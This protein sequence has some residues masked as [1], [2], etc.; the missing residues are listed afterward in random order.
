MKK[1]TKKEV[2]TK[3]DYVVVNLYHERYSCDM[4]LE[5]FKNTSIVDIYNHFN[6]EKD[7]DI[8]KLERDGYHCMGYLYDKCGRYEADDY[9]LKKSECKRFRGY[10]IEAL[11]IV[12]LEKFLKEKCFCSTF[13]GTNKKYGLVDYAYTPVDMR[14]NKN[15]LEKISN[16]L[17]EKY[18]WYQKFIEFT[19][20][21][22]GIK[23]K[24]KKWFRRKRNERTRKIN[25]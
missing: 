23:W 22:K 4:G 8:N 9:A 10:H 24:I 21:V 6:F 15:K 25:E 17:Y 18:E 19:W 13:M 11:F 14:L 16:K 5:I 2:N 3:K 20:E 1:I 12:E 7:F